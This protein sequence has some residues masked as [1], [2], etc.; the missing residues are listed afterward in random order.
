MRRVADRKLTALPSRRARILAFA[1]ILVGGVASGLIGWS[2][3]DLQCT[4]DCGTAEGVGALVGGTIGAIGVAIVSVLALRAMGE[5]RQIQL[6]ASPD[7]EAPPTTSRRNPS[8]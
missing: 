1:A 3:V 5:W 4:G 8:A 6:N 2:F 7:G